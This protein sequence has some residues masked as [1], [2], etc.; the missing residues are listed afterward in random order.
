VTTIQAE[1]ARQ[2]QPPASRLAT[3]VTNVERGNTW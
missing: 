3:G 1:A 2:D